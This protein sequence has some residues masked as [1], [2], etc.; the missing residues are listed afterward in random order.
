MLLELPVIIKVRETLSDFEAHPAY[1]L[2]LYVLIPISLVCSFI[3]LMFIFRKIKSLE[4]KTVRMREMSNYIQKGAS[5]Y[6]HQQS[7]MLLVV[8]ALLFIPVGLTGIEFLENKFLGFFIVG[9]IFLLGALS[10]LISWIYWYDC[11]NKNK[12]ISS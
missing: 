3:C 5:V 10:S 12:Y 11:C 9:V 7:K 1:F 6:L 2:C 8:V 4:E